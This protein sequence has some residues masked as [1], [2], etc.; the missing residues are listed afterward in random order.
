MLDQVKFMETLRA[1]A[2][3]A[4]VSTIPL[5]KEEINGYFDGMELTDE[6]QELVYQY[7]LNP[8]PEEPEET[9]P[10]SEEEKEQEGQEDARP[11]ESAYLRMY[12][13]EI[14]GIEGLTLPEEREAYVKLLDGDETV[15]QRIS[16]HWL[17]KVVDIAKT[18]EKHKVNIEDVIQEG[19][20]GLLMGIQNLLGTHKMIDV[21]EYLKESVQKAIE[22]FIDEMATDDDWESTVLAKTTL[23]HEA[24]KALQ[25]QIGKEPSIQEL[26]DFTKI[27]VEEIEDVLHLSLEDE[28][29]KDQPEST[30]PVKDATIEPWLDIK[31]EDMK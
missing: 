31:P 15:I 8:Q 20:I 24:K 18:Y 7:L 23:I 12:M 10:E 25:E 30:Q 9:Q 1:V 29:F 19:N 6:Q 22:D 14:E 17:T 13:E 11:Q 5:S 21:Q 2:E 27:P 28:K 26:S 16:D 3:V 4:R